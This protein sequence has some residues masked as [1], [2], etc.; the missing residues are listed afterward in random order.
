VAPRLPDS[1]SW[2]AHRDAAA[3]LMIATVDAYAPN[4]KHS[5]LGRQ[6]MRPL[7]LERTFG[8]VDGDIFTARSTWAR[9]SRRG[10]CSA[11]PI[12][13]VRPGPLY[14]RCRHASRR[15]PHRRAGP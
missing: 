15:R 7:D 1:A 10:L 3:D 5:V 8:L 6:I 9:C 2:D 13:A 12:I 11:V 4:F 14:V